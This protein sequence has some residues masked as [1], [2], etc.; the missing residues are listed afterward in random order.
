MIEE[1]LYNKPFDKFTLPIDIQIETISYCNRS[2]DYCPVSLI[3]KEKMKLMPEETFYKL[4]DELDELGFTGT[5]G[6]AVLCEPLMDKRTIK[7]FAYARNKLPGSKIHLATNGDLLT[8]KKI[9]ELLDKSFSTIRITNHEKEFNDEKYL[10]LKNTKYYNRVTVLHM[11]KLDGFLDW[12]GVIKNKNFSKN[13]YYRKSCPYS[14]KTV[15]DYKGNV[16]LCCND[17]Y[18]ARIDD[19]SEKNNI[20]KHKFYDIWKQS[21]DTRLK[22]TTGNHCN[23]IDICNKCTGG[24]SKIEKSIDK[25]KDIYKAATK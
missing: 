5:I 14:V 7:L 11:H 3:P 22:L 9:I 10:W 4:I 6:T 12:A 25:L 16:L 13:I 1:F 19:R 8:K 17:A 20:N 2:C 21:F 18:F 24:Y 23:E 15:I